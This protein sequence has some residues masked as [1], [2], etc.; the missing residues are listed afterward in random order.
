M[1]P[2]KPVGMRLAQSMKFYLKDYTKTHGVFWSK[3]PDTA[4]FLV[5]VIF[6]NS[7]SYSEPQNVY[8]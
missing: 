8:T 1:L 2:P 5:R 6:K 3:T 4:D 7:L